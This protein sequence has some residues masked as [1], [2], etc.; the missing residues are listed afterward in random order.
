MKNALIKKES[1]RYPFSKLRV[2]FNAIFGVM[3]LLLSLLLLISY[4]DTLTVLIYITLTLTITLLSTR[5]KLYLLKRMEKIQSEP[6][7]EESGGT[8]DWKLIAMIALL[9]LALMLP[10]ITALFVSPLWWFICFS[11]FVVGFSLSEIFLYF[12]VEH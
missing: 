5:L 1:V 4:S 10:V 11:S 2:Y 9:A 3:A 7:E 12:S 8:L 6:E